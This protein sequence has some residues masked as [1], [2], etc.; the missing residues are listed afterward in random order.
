MSNEMITQL[1]TVIS[2]QLSDIIYAVQGYVS[3]ASPG[4][5]VQETLGQVVNLISSQ[6]ILSNAGNPNGVLAGTTFQ[7][8]YDTVNAKLYICTTSGNASTA[9]W[10]LIGANI[11][12]PLQGGTGISNPTAHTLPVAEGASNFTFLGP[13]S[14]GQLLIGS[15]SADPVAATIT[16]GTNISVTNGAGSIRIDA[17]GL[18][19]IGWVNVTSSTQAMVADT[20]YVAD[21]STLV[22][23]TLPVTAA[24]GTII[25]VQGLGAGGWQI[26]QNSGQQIIIGS[27]LS[28]IGASGFIAS[29]NQY[30]SIALLCV[31]ANTTWC[32]LGAPQGNITVN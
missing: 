1:P 27:S 11:V 15:S 30:D 32:S 6:T 13:L 4:T 10:T 21:K 16:P 24:F 12:A 20:G 7:L 9:V 8:C 2:A 5:S 23:F 31:T 3:P 17:T 22:T 26:N 29:T 18:A 19:G 14:N 25:Y 28:T